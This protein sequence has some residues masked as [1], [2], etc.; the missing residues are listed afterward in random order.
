MRRRQ[1][2][3]DISAKLARFPMLLVGLQQDCGDMSSDSSLG[4]NLE[5]FAFA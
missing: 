1:E 3:L 5:N 2:L 4:E